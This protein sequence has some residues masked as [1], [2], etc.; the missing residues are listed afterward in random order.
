MKRRKKIGPGKS[1]MFR[2]YI[3][4]K[5]IITINLYYEIFH[6]RFIVPVYDPVIEAVSSLENDLYLV[7]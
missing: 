2:K 1:Y 5:N 4:N 3:L 7:D 6:T